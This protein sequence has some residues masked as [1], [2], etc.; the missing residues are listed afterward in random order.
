MAPTAEIERLAHDG[1]A[2]QRWRARRLL[3]EDPG[4]LPEIPYQDELG[5]FLGASDG[6]SPGATG[7]GICHLAILGE[8]GSGAATIA[9]DWLQEVRTPA[10]GWLDRP[11]AMP[12]PLDAAGAPRV[13]ATA[14]AVSGLL[15]A[16][17]D[18]GAAA[19]TLLRGDSDSDGGFTGGGYP[20]FAAAAAFWLAEGQLS[21][22]AEWALRW[23]REEAVIEDAWELATALTFW[24]AAGVPAEHP[25]VELFLDDLLEMQQAD[26]DAGL[27]L[28]TAELR[29]ALGA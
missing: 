6:A 27:L 28:R 11:E 9:A 10:G 17:R 29:S 8:K 19:L 18:P 3:G 4:P 26:D 23:A 20:T 1:D 25:S 5:A 14:G 16:G 2:W 15:V 13:W 22:T 7:E 24:T 21:E 12:G